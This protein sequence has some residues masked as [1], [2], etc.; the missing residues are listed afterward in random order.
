MLDAL[1]VQIKA[2]RTKIQVSGNMPI[3]PETDE[4]FVTIERTPASVRLALPR[5]SL[6]RGFG[7]LAEDPWPGGGIPTA[8]LPVHHDPVPVEHDLGR[9]LNYP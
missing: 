8:L 7:K 9:L 2:C 6:Q 5:L 1:D 3:V 4:D